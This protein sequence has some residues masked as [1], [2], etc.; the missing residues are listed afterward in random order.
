M[1]PAL[2]L[3]Y[4]LIA[5]LRKEEITLPDRGKKNLKVLGDRVEGRWKEERVSG[6]L[7]K[8]EDS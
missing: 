5:S 6:N 8:A 4:L 3:R 2:G 7:K 1:F